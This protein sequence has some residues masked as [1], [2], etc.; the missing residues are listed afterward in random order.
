[1]A[2]RIESHVTVLYEVPDVETLK[3]A[4]HAVPTLRLRA[5]RL[6][7]WDADAP[8]IY[9]AIEDPHGDL[10]RFRAS[11]TGPRT[12]GYLPH[13]T[14]LHKDSVVRAGQA[15]EAWTSLRDTIFETDF[16]VGELIVY[17]QR[18]DVWREAA[19]LRFP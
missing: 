6:G 15:D 10:D 13:I 18:G 7:R 8:G 11:V 9:L 4:V 12:D 19:R 1:M 17:E 3:A 2:A 14:I 16:S 5:T